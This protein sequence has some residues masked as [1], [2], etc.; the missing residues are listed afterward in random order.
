MGKLFEA[1]CSGVDMNHRRFWAVMNYVRQHTKVGDWVLEVG[2]DD[3]AF[4][5]GFAL[6]GR[7]VD[8]LD[9]LR[10]PFLTHLYTYMP[11]KFDDDFM[12]DY[13]AVDSPGGYQAVCLGEVLEHVKDPETMLARACRICHGKLIVSVPSFAAA[14]HRCIYTEDTFKELIDPFMNT[15]KFYSFESHKK[16]GKF[17][18]LAMGE[19]KGVEA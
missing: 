16:P 17:Q 8:A 19:P 5:V 9:H 2:C 10:T 7:R 6:L 14:G 18:W 3:G 13:A 12:M 4:A 15:E 1:I 11:R